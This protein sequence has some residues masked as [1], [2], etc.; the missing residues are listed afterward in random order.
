MDERQ[1]KRL[2]ARNVNWPSLHA[3]LHFLFAFMLLFY[4]WLWSGRRNAMIFLLLICTIQDIQTKNKAKTACCIQWLNQVH[5]EGICC[6]IDHK[7]AIQY[8][9]KTHKMSVKQYALLLKCSPWTLALR[10]RRDR[11][12]VQLEYCTAASSWQEGWSCCGFL[13]GWFMHK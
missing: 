13:I 6:H 5:S 9:C 4:Q 2:Y 3:M 7:G 1:S 8:A 10:Q 11:A 12:V